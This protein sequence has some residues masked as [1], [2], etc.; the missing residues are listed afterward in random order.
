MNNT[1]DMVHKLGFADDEIAKCLD[2]KGLLSIELEFTRKCNLR[3]LYCY[4][5]AGEAVENE[6][7]L[8]ELK[9]VVYQARDLGAK[10]I[11][12]LGGGEPLLY[13]GVMDVVDYIHSLGLQQVLFTNGTLITRE[14]AQ[15]LFKKNVSV[16]MKSNSMISEVQDLLAGAKGV[17][18]NI[19]KGLQLLKDTGYPDNNV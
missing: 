15:F 19:R 6:L 7:E 10:K 18:Q 17:F 1:T 4:S 13:H 8:N 3:C 11:I 2:K 14:I 9:A 5:N 12:L 16:I